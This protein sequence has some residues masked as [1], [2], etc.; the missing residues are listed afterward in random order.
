MDEYTFHLLEQVYETWEIDLSDKNNPFYNND[1]LQ[2]VESRKKHQSYNFLKHEGFIS[3][4]GFNSIVTI[5]VK[6]AAYVEECRR[7]QALYKLHEQNAQ[8]QEQNIQI[9]NS[10]RKCQWGLLAITLLT[11]A[12]NLLT[13]DWIQN[14][15]WVPAKE[16]YIQFLLRLN[17]G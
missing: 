8:I 7:N 2:T 5:T 10:L 15:I 1:K 11:L 14:E 3:S 13:S 12:S 4:N 17:P 6:G 9:Q 16:L